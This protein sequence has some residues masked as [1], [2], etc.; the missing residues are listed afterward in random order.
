MKGI[1]TNVLLRF[2]VQDDE[3]Q[4]L[5]A[6]RFIANHC[7][8]ENPGLINHVVLCEL[9]WALESTYRYP[10]HRVLYALNQIMLAFQLR[11]D[12]R[13]EVRAAI[14]EYRIG[15]DF[16]DALISIVNRRLG[17]EHTVTFD[18]KASRRDGFRGL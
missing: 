16:T 15:A 18:R 17:C 4:A 3:E 13:E 8:E 12:E 5:K 6:V 2:F 11:V 7:T 9:V 14:I 10:R 1:D